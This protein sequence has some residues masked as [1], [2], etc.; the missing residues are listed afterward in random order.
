MSPW[1]SLEIVKLIVAALT[2]IFIIVVGFWLNKRMRRIEQLQWSNQKIIEKRI[3]FYDKVVPLINDLLCFYTYV[4]RWKEL[5]PEDIIQIKRELD[6]EFY[7]YAPLFPAK[8]FDKYAA[9]I[10]LCFK[11]HSGWGE[12]AKLLSLF[13]K[14]KEAFGEKWSLDW[15]KLFLPNEMKSPQLLQTSYNELVKSLADSLGLNLE[16]SYLPK[17]IMSGNIA[18]QRQ[19]EQA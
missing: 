13:D 9:M 7:I 2:P 5:T 14:R 18:P 3:A 6:R 4:G 10:R 15:D 11:M 16:F 8:I 1:N 12:S 17:S 19:T